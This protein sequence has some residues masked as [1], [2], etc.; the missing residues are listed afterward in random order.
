[1]WER[2]VRRGCSEARNV[3]SWQFLFGLLRKTLPFSF[4]IFQMPGS[5][6]ANKAPSASCH[7]QG[8]AAGS[9]TELAAPV[10]GA[11]AFRVAGTQSWGC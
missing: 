9:Q 4:S 8:A 1:M 6:H 2:L 10:P 3:K 11:Q 7:S 5:Q